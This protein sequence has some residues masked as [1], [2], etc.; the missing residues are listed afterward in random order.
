M[1]THTCT[2]TSACAHT[3]AWW[4]LKSRKPNNAWRLEPRPNHHLPQ[5]RPCCA[6]VVPYSSVPVV[7]QYQPASPQALLSWQ[8]LVFTSTWSSALARYFNPTFCLLCISG[9]CTPSAPRC[10]ARKCP[11]NCRV[12][13]NDALINSSCC[14]MLF[15]FTY[16]T[17]CINNEYLCLVTVYMKYCASVTA[18]DSSSR[19]GE[20]HPAT[21]SGSSPGPVNAGIPRQ[22][23]S[24][25]PGWACVAKGLWQSFPAAL[26][27]PSHN[28]GTLGA[29]VF[30]TNEVQ[31]DV[32]N[33]F[34]SR[35]RSNRFFIFEEAYL[36][37]CY[38][39]GGHMGGHDDT[40][41]DQ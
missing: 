16:R 20:G 34:G 1:P 18:T 11:A 2:H 24:P 22:Q 6:T 13:P 29:K 15:A 5:R 26:L 27:L 36:S 25:A 8:P 35:R 7:C 39:G 17:V 9:T 10:L 30:R 40:R 14:Q 32:I 21:N 31:I 33:T 23:C 28:P 38:V 12:V 41:Q 19:Q 37:G 3:E 4:C